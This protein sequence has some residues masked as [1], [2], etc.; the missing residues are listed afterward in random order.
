MKMRTVFIS[1][2]FC[3]FCTAGVVYGAEVAKIGII[4]FQ[5]V[6]DASIA[7]KRSAVEIKSQGK[8]M[9][10][11]LKEKEAKIEEL[12]KSLE[13]KALVM[14][15]EAREE[16]ERNFRIMANDLQS[17]KRRYL[18]NLKDL[19]LKLSDE[20]KKDVFEIAE[21]IGRREGYLLILER[22]FGGVVYAP[23]TIDITDRVIEAY[24]A[25]DTKRAGKK[26]KSTG[27]SEEKES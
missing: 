26:D 1:F 9:E 15:L 10:Q 3:L 22:R 18:E 21:E 13:Q 2:I 25:L 7:G 14:S 5:T 4:D 23:D 16:K 24:D 17:L 20:I 6:I 12:Q 8:K 27:R 19:N 11:V